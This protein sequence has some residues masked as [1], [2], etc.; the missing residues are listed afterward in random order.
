MTTANMPVLNL[1]IDLDY[2]HIQCLQ[3]GPVPTVHVNT[4]EDISVE[5]DIT[6]TH[7]P[8]SVT[9]HDITA[10]SARLCDLFGVTT[11]R[12]LIRRARTGTGTE[13]VDGL[14]FEAGPAWDGLVAAAYQEWSLFWNPLPMDPALS[15]LD[16]V[17]AAYRIPGFGGATTARQH[18]PTALPAVQVLERLLDA[19]QISDTA[20]DVVSQGITA[21][22]ASLLPDSSRP[23]TPYTLPLALTATD[24]D[25]ILTDGQ[26]PAPGEVGILLVG[27]A[28]WRLTGH[29]QAATAENKILVTQHHRN[30]DA[31]TITV[32]TQPTSAAGPIP[33]Y[34]AFITEPW[35]GALIAHT[36]LRPTTTGVLQ[37]H[38]LPARPIQATDHVDI[39][40][41]SLPG[42][43][44]TNPTQRISDQARR[45][46]S[47]A[48]TRTRYEQLHHQTTTGTPTNHTNHVPWTITEHTQTNTL[49]NT[50]ST[51]THQPLQ[52]PYLLSAKD[53]DLAADT[54]ETRL[55]GTEEAGP[56]GLTWSR[57]KA[58]Q[59]LHISVDISTDLAAISDMIKIAV[60]AEDSVSNFLIILRSFD[61]DYLVGDIKVQDPSGKLGFQLSTLSMQSVEITTDLLETVRASIS[62]ATFDGIKAWQQLLS[63]LPLRSE[64]R[65]AISKALP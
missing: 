11:G 60:V 48:L 45:Q 16:T 21:V 23:E 1:E 8:V 15:A 52:T 22:R 39:R 26:T 37:G 18:A 31:I 61:D 36:T 19:G 20:T 38:T 62:G 44:E 55:E 40:H 32:P 65:E 12:E 4:G 41:P 63:A 64:L 25:L 59:I 56:F 57:D 43:P 34:D 9:V 58:T 47:R 24:L 7:A 35:T 49:T 46:A 30:P 51:P 54:D 28:D 50:V 42:T 33:V 14:V 29:G 5:I 27:S 13:S 2:L 17:A 53:F 3:P 10:A 6:R